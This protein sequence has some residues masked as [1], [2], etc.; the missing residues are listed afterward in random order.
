MRSVQICVYFGRDR[1]AQDVASS[2]MFGHVKRLDNFKMV[3]DEKAGCY[4]VE[5]EAN[6]REYKR[7]SYAAKMLGCKVTNTRARQLYR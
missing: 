7:L 6:K 2:E 1:H 3:R 5:A 4:C